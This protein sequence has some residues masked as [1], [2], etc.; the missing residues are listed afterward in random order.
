MS[1]TI[2]LCHFAITF[3]DT[4]E[5]LEACPTP[6]V[7][8]PVLAEPEGPTL[9]TLTG[10]KPPEN[11]PAIQSVD[12]VIVP[13]FAS[14]I[15]YALQFTQNV[16]TIPLSY[17]GQRGSPSGDVTLESKYV[18]DNAPKWLAFKFRQTADEREFYDIQRLVGGN[19]P[20]TY[21]TN[22]V[23]APIPPENVVTTLSDGTVSFTGNIDPD[24]DAVIIPQ[25]GAIIR[26]FRAEYPDLVLLVTSTIRP[27]KTVDFYIV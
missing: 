20:I 4:N 2:N 1:K 22:V 5:R 21:R 10:F 12:T 17:I 16:K 13:R 8:T 3:A 23:F 6:L 14:A 27:D 7:F 25:D 11:L 26:Y 9:S 19:F 18:L 15:A 24:T